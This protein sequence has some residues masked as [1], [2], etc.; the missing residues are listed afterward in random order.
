MRIYVGRIP[1]VKTSSDLCE[2]FMKHG[3]V[4]SA[5]I[6]RDDSN[7]QSRG[8]GF[9]TMTS[10]EQAQRAI[11][12]LHAWPWEGRPLIVMPAKNQGWGD[13]NIHQ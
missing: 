4:Y 2:L 9:V 11:E 1:Y 13:E 7:H 12:A 8:Y 6:C 5:T 10:D 3:Q